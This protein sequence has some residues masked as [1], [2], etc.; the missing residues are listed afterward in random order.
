MIKSGGVRSEATLTSTILC[1]ALVENIQPIKTIKTLN[2]LADFFFFL[3]IRA[4]LPQ[5]FWW[6]MNSPVS[7]P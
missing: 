2:P 3:R 4:W 5:G 7:V 1:T 6:Q